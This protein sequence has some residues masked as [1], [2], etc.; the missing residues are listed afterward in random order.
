MPV[1][2]NTSA[3][4][5][6][7][8]ADQPTV[9]RLKANIGRLSTATLQQLDIS[10]PWYRGLRPDERSALGMVAQKGIAS[11]V[12]WYQRPASPAWVLSDVFGT[13][14]TE[15]TRSIS[16]QK[17][18]QLIRVVVQVVEDR[19]PELAGSEVQSKLREAVLRYSREVAFAAADVYA[20]AAETRGAWDTR[21]EALV[22]DAILRG[23]SSD[24]LR[25][26]IA[27]VGW[28]SAAPVTVMVGGSP[29]EANATFVNELRRATGRLAEDTLV[30]IQGERLILVLGGLEDKAFSYTRLSELFGP[31]PVVYG[32]PAL[33]LVEAGPSAQAAFAGLTAARAWPAAPRPVAADDLWPERVMSGDDTARKALVESIYTPLLG[34]S[35][36]LAETLSA[37]LSLGHSLEATARELFVHA[38]TVRY[39]LRRVCDVTGWDPMLPREAFVLQTAL[40]V[41]RL[42]PAGKA[43]PEK[44]AVRL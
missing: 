8:E 19:V 22:V 32:P 27:A 11:F 42:A 34:A 7:P 17:A 10:L 25:S 2:P 38:N 30:G 4:S 24:A 5:A 28:S 39:R 3:A 35:N 40:V 18:L 14:P 6:P 15:L 13:A 43:A 36:G 20:R 12:N 29:A 33:S 16:L 41:G 31:G 37:Y 23:E 26:R 9:E 21:L 1:R 44:P